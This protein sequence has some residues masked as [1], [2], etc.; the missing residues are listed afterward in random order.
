MAT[1]AGGKVKAQEENE[2]KMEGRSSILRYT[3]TKGE[4]KRR[5]PSIKQERARTV[6]EREQEEY[7]K[8]LMQNVLI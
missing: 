1:E 7:H 3:D 8:S 6:M 5:R 2:N 4:T